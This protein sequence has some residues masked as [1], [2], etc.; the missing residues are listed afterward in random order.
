MK[1]FT[2]QL[3][4]LKSSAQ[5]IVRSHVKDGELHFSERQISFDGGGW[6]NA[7]YIDEDDIYRLSAEFVCDLA[8][9][10]ICEF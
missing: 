7:D 6:D 4:E 3:D 10:L 2:E 5:K 8:D 1:T 9:E